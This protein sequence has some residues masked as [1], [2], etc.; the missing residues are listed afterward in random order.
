MKALVKIALLTT[1]AVLTLV[2]AASAQNG[3][4]SE[5]VLTNEKVITMVKAG[6]FSGIIV[7]KIR[8]SKTN[9]NTSTDELVRLQQSRVPAEIINA[10]VEA[11]T[12]ASTITSRTGAGDA[13]KGDPNDPASA[14]EA[15]IYLFESKDR[16]RLVTQLEPS[17]ST[18]SKSGGFFKSAMT[19]GIAKIKSKAVI[20][21][22]S[23]RLQLN[24]V[25]PVFYFYFEVKN[26]GLSN[27]GNAYSGSS[28]SPNE[29]VL[30]KMDQKKNAR[31]LIV[32]Q[33]NLFGAES[34]T[35]DKYSRPFDYEKLAP[36]VYKVTPRSDLDDGEYGFFYGGSTPIAAYG[37][38]G[39]GISP[40]IF[41][42]GIRRS[43]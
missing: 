13:S 2:P 6:L 18:Q 26:A 38:F 23:A 40:K 36:G 16:Q 29:F 25:R 32:G 22:N 28:T 3:T 11:T 1:I 37:Y 24:S 41:D 9:F 15:G 4:S 39:A 8:S 12:T 42:F 20:A 31:E 7:N 30:V 19:Y 35:L 14:H 17:I 10:M 33:A 34:G 43:R 21:N 27:S 5:E